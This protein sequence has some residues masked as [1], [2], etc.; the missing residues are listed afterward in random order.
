MCWVLERWLFAQT[1]APPENDWA[2]LIG[3]FG[4]D[5]FARLAE[6]RAW[7]A[8][9]RA[10]VALNLAIYSLKAGL[11]TL[12]LEFI[13]VL[14]CEESD[15]L[16]RHASFVSVLEAYLYRAVG[17]DRWNEESASTA[18]KSY[19]ESL[20]IFTHE[21]LEVS[22]T[23]ILNRLIEIAALADI[24]K[25]V[26]ECLPYLIPSLEVLLGEDGV[27]QIQ[28]IGRRGLSR[29]NFLDHRYV[30]TWMRAFKGLRFA[31]ALDHPAPYVWRRDPE[32]CRLIE[33]VTRLRT[34]VPE[35]SVPPQSSQEKS[36]VAVALPDMHL[37]EGGTASERLQNAQIRFD[38]HLRQ[39]V[40]NPTVPELDNAF[41]TSL[42]V[43]SRLDDRTVLVQLFVTPDFG[44]AVTLHIA[45]TT[46]DDLAL[47]Q[48]TWYG[49]GSDDGVQGTRTRKPGS[50]M[51]H[52]VHKTRCEIT[53]TPW[54]GKVT[55]RGNRLLATALDKV[56]GRGA[57][58]LL[59]QY[60]QA[61][62]QHVCIVPHGPLHYFPYHLLSMDGSFLADHWVVT[63]LPDIALLR[64][65]PR[66]DNPQ[67]EK[68]HRTDTFVGFGLGFEDSKRSSF[69]D[70]IPSARDGA[71]RISEMFRERAIL[72]N[73]ATKAAFIS[74]APFARFVHLSTH[75]EHS[76]IAPSFQRIFL[77]STDS[78]D[79]ILYAYEVSELNLQGVELLTLG[80]C[81]TSLGRFDNSDN[82]VG[83]TS[84]LFLAGVHSIIGTLWPVEVE[85]SST[86]FDTLYAHLNEGASKLDAFSA[87]QRRTR[88]VC[89]EFRDWGAFHYSGTW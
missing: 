52:L 43:Q 82:L 11:E 84:S 1:T 68:E 27:L 66:R 13:G 69:L 47:R 20:A 74:R 35:S 21:R 65:Q 87:A 41:E 30:T 42:S 72:D 58:E 56:L 83:L 85:A 28:T 6:Q 57:V 60:R 86:F 34:G 3:D 79:G 22:S 45:F 39:S 46:N 37:Q 55:R 26:L 62:K 32:A 4:I 40:R 10:E 80:A 54:L 48:T 2:Q 61:G 50:D 25:D 76:A 64:E 51:G 38:W 5:S 24:C 53:K 67:L 44:G 89:P 9:E 59:R 73:D 12:G 70:P 8:D 63:Y 29:G 17:A 7:G 81:E 31:C 16:T 36:I 49:T 77:A 33:R 18:A 23:D 19:F 15:V 78:E 71:R 14:R 88:V 75:A